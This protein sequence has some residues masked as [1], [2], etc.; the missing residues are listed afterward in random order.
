MHIPLSQIFALILK[1]KYLVLFPIG[2]IEG[3]II[4]VISGL[5]VSM[6]QLNFLLSWAV[7]I[8]ADLVGDLLLYYLGVWGG[9]SFIPKYGKYFGANEK[10]MKQAEI[11]F[12]NHPIKTLLF[13]KWSHAFGFAIFTAAGITRQRFDRYIYINIL[14]TIPK[15]LALILVGYYFGQAYVKIDRYIHYAGYLIFGLG[16]L[17]VGIFIALNKL[18]DKK[19]EEE[20]AKEAGL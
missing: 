3:P 1:Y 17:A 4:A 6:K 8:L 10:R 11:F 20:I 15:T 14:G 7:L 9:K 5:L 16:L 2:V 13:G 19:L 18:A 12:N